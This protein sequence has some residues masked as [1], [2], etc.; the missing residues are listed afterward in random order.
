MPITTV[1]LNFYS[2]GCNLYCK[3]LSKFQDIT[4]SVYFGYPGY[5]QRNDALQSILFS[6]EVVK[7]LEE[8]DFDATIGISSGVLFCGIVGTPNRL[9]YCFIG[10][11]VRVAYQVVHEY[12]DY[13]IICCLN[14]YF[15]TRRFTG[16]IF[17]EVLKR[18]KE[19]QML[20]STF[21]EVKIEPKKPEYTMKCLGRDNEK[22]IIIDSLQNLKKNIKDLDDTLPLILISG[23]IGMGKT[24]FLE[25]A[26]NKAET[27]GFNLTI[28]ICNNSFE[29]SFENAWKI[30]QDILQKTGNE[31]QKKISDIFENKKNVFPLHTLNDK[32]NTEF[33]HVVSLYSEQDIR[34]MCVTLIQKSVKDNLILICVDNIEH[35]GTESW[36]FLQELLFLKVAIVIATVTEEY[37]PSIHFVK[38]VIQQLYKSINMRPLDEEELGLLACTVLNV[39]AINKGFLPYC[40]R[41]HNR[42]K[43]RRTNADKKMRPFRRLFWFPRARSSLSGISQKRAEEQ[44]QDFNKKKPFEA[45]V[46]APKHR[47]KR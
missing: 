21:F 41:P 43:F 30:T 28:R 17:E 29:E 26:T 35:M 46:C 13:Y 14:T 12:S 4:V 47:T 19:T 45:A 20:P 5:R 18:I 36:L 22:K 8:N 31:T 2:K 11:P 6:Q 25:W 42:F 38:Y 39:E 1:H 44:N 34:N 9:Q 32:L 15:L 23:H 10:M 3:K 16:D 27:I 24:T 7:T 33:E 40:E 37:R